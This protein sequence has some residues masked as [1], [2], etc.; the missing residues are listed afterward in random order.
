MVTINVTSFNEEK[1]LVKKSC[2]LLLCKG[3]V[4]AVKNLNEI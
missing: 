2:L 3:E 1:G 4:I